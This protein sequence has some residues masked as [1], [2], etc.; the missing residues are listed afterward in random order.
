L[1]AAVALRPGH[2]DPAAFTHTPAELAVDTR[3]LHVL[4][5]E[6]AGVDFLTQES[7]HFLA[8]L[9]SDLGEANR[10]ELKHI[11]LNGKKS[12]PTAHRVRHACRACQARLPIGLRCQSLRAR[13]ACATCR[14]AGGARA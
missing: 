1:V 6:G 5:V 13:T 9:F 2:A 11:A 4:G 10:F 3:R 14:C 12:V 7:A 8:Q